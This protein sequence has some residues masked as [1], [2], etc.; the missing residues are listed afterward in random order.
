MDSILFNILMFLAGFA[1]LGGGAEF[2]VRGA[3]RIAARMNVSSAVIGLTIVAF[4]TSLPELMVS[5]IGN[6][7]GDGGAEIA[8][9]NIVGSNIANLGLVLGIAGILAIIPVEKSILRREFP[10]LIATS[11]VFM[12]L[13][14]NG[15][16]NRLE[17]LVL[18]AGL[19]VFSYYSYTS[20]RSSHHESAEQS[21]DVLEAID[22]DIVV[23]SEHPLRDGLLV[24]FG[25]IAVIVG[26]ELLVRSAEALARAIGVSDL[27]IGL[28][29]VS[30]GTGLP[31]LATTVVAVLRKETGIAFG[32]VVGSNLFNMLSIGGIT[33]LIRPLPVP[34]HMILFDFPVMIG[35]TVLVLVLCLPLPHQLSRWKGSVLTVLYVGYVFSLFTLKGI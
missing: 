1:L 5:V 14:W 15:E 16:I 21:L 19:V 7:E 24:I 17:A 31:E 26:A 11:I 25:L 3:S 2:L 23:P 29:L 8:I 28:T 6:L 18:L 35:I 34:G 22:D 33:A 10:L 13:S 27:V 20:A 4:G 30:L 12:A 32:N 9:G